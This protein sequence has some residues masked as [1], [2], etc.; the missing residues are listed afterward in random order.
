MLLA[1]Q[2][3][4]GQARRRAVISLKHDDP[5]PEQIKKMQ[6][7]ARNIARRVARL[8]KDDPYALADDLFQQGWIAWFSYPY[9][10]DT[11]RFIKARSVM[12]EYWR[13]WRWQ[14]HYRSSIDE[15][16][17]SRNPAKTRQAHRPTMEFCNVDDVESTLTMNSQVESA[18]FAKELIEKIEKTFADRRNSDKFERTLIDCILDNGVRP[19]GK[20]QM[21]AK[22]SIGPQ[23][24]NRCLAEI[25]QIVKTEMEAAL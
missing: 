13:R 9:L 22:N 24:K 8:A 3:E 23:A 15:T 25:R 17:I 11:L 20:H 19:S 2:F 16:G 18:I 7:I 14:I 6:A 1:Q 21:D 10:G 4:T 5:T 12:S